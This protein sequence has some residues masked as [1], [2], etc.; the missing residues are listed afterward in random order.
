MS[1]HIAYLVRVDKRLEL[2]Y[3]EFGLRLRAPYPEWLFEAASEIIRRIEGAKT[4]GAIDE[5]EMLAEFEAEESNP[6]SL[7]IL[8]Y[9]SGAR[10]ETVPQCM[11]TLGESD[12]RWVARE[13]RKPDSNSI[14]E[15]LHD[16][17]LTRPPAAE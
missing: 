3:P 17:M 11:V 7:D 13:A 1:E 15:R 16:T 8:K 9:E 14:G 10:F 2:V 6:V 4:Q 12:Y 5:A